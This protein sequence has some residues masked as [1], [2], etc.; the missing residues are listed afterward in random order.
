MSDYYTAHI[1][2]GNDEIEVSAKLY[3]HGECESGIDQLGGYW[4]EVTE[5]PI[6]TE[7]VAFDDYGVEMLLT[8]RELLD[9]EKQMIKQ[10]WDEKESSYGY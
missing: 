10:Y 3:E 5:D 6:F 7:F 1:F 4:T 2:R 8:P 9:V